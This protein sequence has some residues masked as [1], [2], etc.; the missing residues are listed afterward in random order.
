MQKTGWDDILVCMDKGHGVRLESVLPRI[1]RAE[2]IL[3]CIECQLS[4]S[5][6]AKMNGRIPFLC[7]KDDLAAKMVEGKE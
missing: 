5:G 4:W 1:K 6:G 7:G 3:T 2:V